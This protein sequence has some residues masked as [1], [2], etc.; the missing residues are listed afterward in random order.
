MKNRVTEILRIKYPVVQASMAWI[1]DAKMAAAVSNAGGMGVLGPNAGQKTVTTDPSETAERMRREIHKIREL[2][3]KPFAVQY[4]LPIPQF[5]MTRIFGEPIFKILIEEKIKYVLASGYTIPDEIK[6]LKDH[7]FTVIFRELE[8][9]VTAAVEAEKAGVD[10]FIATGYGEGGAM[11]T[12]RI[13]TMTIVPLIADAVKIPILAAGGIV[14]SRQVRASLDLGAEG[15]YVG[16][17]FVASKEC[18]AS[19]VCKND[20]VDTKSE[21][22]VEYL[23]TPTYW[24]GT[25]RG[26]SLELQ[27]MTEDGA[28]REEITKRMS[29]IGALKTGMLEGDLENGINSVSDAVG[30]IKSIRSCK[31]IIENL[32]KGVK[33]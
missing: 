3:D 16:T 6:K 18:P 9:T 24:R 14:D 22:L 17:L 28:T 29:D 30:A 5:E 7:G 25:P 21:D 8:P 2:T 32:M 12:R 1:T 20:I 15:V 11:P 26:L 31:E 13:S 27:K 23:G 19:D 4:I 10:I 33:F